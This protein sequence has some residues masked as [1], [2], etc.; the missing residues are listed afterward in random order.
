MRNEVF[1]TN[2]ELFNGNENGNNAIG[3]RL[4]E[5]NNAHF[6]WYISLHAFW[7]DNGVSSGRLQ[8]KK[9]QFS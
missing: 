3:F 8:E 2:F 5:Q 6:F 9:I 7:T 1:L 4:A